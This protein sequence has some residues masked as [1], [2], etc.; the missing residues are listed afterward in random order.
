MREIEFRGLR[1]NGEFVYGYLTKDLEKTTA[2]YDEYS[3]RIHWHPETGGEANAPVKNGT[4][5]QYT[6]IKDCAGAKIFDGDIVIIIDDELERFEELKYLVEWSEDAKWI[7]RHSATEFYDV[8]DFSLMV[9]GNIHE[10][11]S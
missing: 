1:P 11:Q 9:I 4:I 8:G 7:V 5:G 2:Y 10:V 6:G 3:Y